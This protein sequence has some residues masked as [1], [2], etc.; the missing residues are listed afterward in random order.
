MQV[1]YGKLVTCA[2]VI[3]SINSTQRDGY[4]LVRSRRGNTVV[5]SH[6]KYRKVLRYVDPRTEKVNRNLDVAAVLV[7][8]KDRPEL[9]YDV[10]YIRW[11]DSRNLG[12]GDRLMVG[13][14]P[15][16]TSLFLANATHRGVIQPTF[17]EG[18]LSQII[19]AQNL[20]ETRL[21][22]LSMPVEGG[23]S[24]GAVFDPETGEVYGMVF[25]G[26][27]RREQDIPMPFTYA[28]PS[29]VIAPFISAINFKVKA[30]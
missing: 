23:M 29:E 16:G 28:V 12:V 6:V 2:H 27:N 1:D 8:V 7:V 30:E 24:G 25:A 14:Y 26:L 5:L 11:G 21:L 15:L 9:P 3:E 22:Q 4:L 10:P 20:S 17:F 13:G 19:P 18:I